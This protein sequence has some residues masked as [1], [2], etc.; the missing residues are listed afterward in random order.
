MK[1]YSYLI[2]NGNCREAMLFYKQ[3][4]GGKLTFQTLGESAMGE[5]MPPKMRRMILQA[6]LVKDELIVMG[7][8]ITAD[9]GLIKGNAVSIML[10]CGSEREIR[11]CYRRLSAGGKASYPP[12]LNFQGVF[13]SELTDRY[14]NNWILY[15]S[16]KEQGEKKYFYG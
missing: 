13:F 15:F 2:F 6:S 14:G 1:V 16:G 12:Q 3:C 9:Q 10:Q 5:N 11:D 7:T 8:D 4:L